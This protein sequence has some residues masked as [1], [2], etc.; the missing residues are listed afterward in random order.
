M[1][2]A[3]AAWVWVPEQARTIET[4]DFLLV[5]YPDWFHH[6]VELARISPAGDLAAAVD[7][8]LHAA[9]TFDLPEDVELVAWARLAAPEGLLDVYASRGGVV[10]ETL[11]VLALDLAAGAPDLGEPAPGV[12]VRWVDDLK[13]LRDFAQIGVA[14]F[15]G[16][17]TP[18]EELE[19]ALATERETR[20]GGRGGHLV[21]YEGGR[22]VGAGGV[23][24]EGGD[25]R[26]WGGGV[27][28]DV[29]GRGVYRALLAE[30]LAEGLRQGAGL[31]IVKGRIA[32]S[33]PILRR[34]GF[35][36]Y[37]REVSCTIP[38]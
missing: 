36:V 12:E 34:A 32:T 18:E 11:D 13:G 28:E 24:I 38:L 29:R 25:A 20:A 31:A 15:G 2:A 17:P 5:R 10:D 35:H 3:S 16:K 8:A 30:R 9:R 23:S 1:A 26:L 4:D 14:V 22:P 6:Q 37:G 21:A 33:G 19:G 27:L 7:A